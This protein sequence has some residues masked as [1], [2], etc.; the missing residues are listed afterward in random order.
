MTG[1]VAPD[2]I[3]DAIGF[4]LR[5]VAGHQPIQVRHGIRSGDPVLHHRRQ[6]V[7][8]GGIANREVFLLDGGEHVDRGIAGPR[9]ETVDLAQI[10]GPSVEGSLEQGFLEVRRQLLLR[11][12][13]WRKI[14]GR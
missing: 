14:V 5:H 7:E 13:P 2:A 6:I 3:G 12:I 10:S 9:H 4:E 8:R 11:E 1:I